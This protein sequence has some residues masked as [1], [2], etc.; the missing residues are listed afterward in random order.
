MDEDAHPYGELKSEAMAASLRHMA[1]SRAAGRVKLSDGDLNTLLG[2]VKKFTDA[3]C[4]KDRK[5]WIPS[6]GQ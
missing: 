2:S 4:R 5:K 1:V 3:Q 6:N